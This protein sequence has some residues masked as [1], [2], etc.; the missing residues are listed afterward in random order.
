MANLFFYYS[1]MN[2]GKSTTLL[3]ASFNYRER[4]METLLMT[5]SF[6]DRFGKGKIASRIGLEAPALLFDAKTDMAGLILEQVEKGKVDCVLIDE[7]QFLSKEQVWQLSD[8]A[9]IHG[10][11][12][13]CYGIRTD[14]QGQLFEGSKWLLA[15]A[16]KLNELKTI[17]HCGRKAGM[18]LRVDENGN[19]IREGAQV[20]IGGNDRYVPVCRRHF[21]EAMSE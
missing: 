5:V 13:L 18:V 14:F 11:P 1:S 12:V 15:W 16:D 9:D 3:Q 20:E 21:K 2:A 17:C 10:I 6:D 4:G 7:A 8:I 19:P